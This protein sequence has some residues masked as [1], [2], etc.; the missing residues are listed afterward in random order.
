[1][2]ENAAKGL[3]VAGSNLRHGPKNKIVLTNIVVSSE[4]WWIDRTDI[5]AA[6]A[7]CMHAALGIVRSLV[8]EICPVPAV[9]RVPVHLRKAVRHKANN[10]LAI[11]VSN[12]KRTL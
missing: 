5:N 10:Y 9:R 8:H 12:G 3:D 2:G 6:R 4:R 1:L 7:V 11:E